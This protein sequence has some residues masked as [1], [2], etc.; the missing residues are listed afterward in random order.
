M[1][2]VNDALG[3]VRA[4][5]GDPRGGWL[6][7]NYLLPILDL[8]CADIVLNLK[9]GSSMN[10]AAVVPILNVPAGTSSLYPWQGANLKPG[11]DKNRL[12]PV[13][14]LAG[15]TDPIQVFVKPAGSN[16]QNYAMIRQRTTLP[17]VNPTW[18]AG[19]AVGGYLTWAWVG[20]QLVITPTQTALDI[21]V[22]GR[23]TVP[24]LINGDMI[25]PGGEDLWIPLV[26]DTAAIAGIERSNPQILEGYATR[27]LRSQDNLLAD[28]IRQGQGAPARFQ[29]VSR[30]SGNGYISWFWG[31]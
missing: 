1:R 13:P 31:L 17:H 28:I 9:N 8:S 19:N 12:N 3:K 5:L 23:F 25:V 10:M 20:N 6:K 21:E 16:P 29:K 4:L 11:D 30:D 18:N 26:F 15:L 24:P 22:T 14:V 27:S 7:D 2:T